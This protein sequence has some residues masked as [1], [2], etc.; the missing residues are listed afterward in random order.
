M[1][2]ATFALAFGS[3]SKRVIEESNP[4][5]GIG[6]SVLCLSCRASFKRLFFDSDDDDIS[7]R[8]RRRDRHREMG[9]SSNKEA[10]VSL[11]PRN[12]LVAASSVNDAL[13]PQQQQHQPP[14]ARYEVKMFYANATSQAKCASSLARQLYDAHYYHGHMLRFDQA[15]SCQGQG[16][17]GNHSWSC[18]A[19]GIRAVATQEPRPVGP[20]HKFVPRPRFI[21]PPQ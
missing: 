2:L 11:T 19:E 12:L 13:S 3:C 7:T 21:P 18:H 1:G 8:H 16:N 17:Q 15:V 20:T 6:G 5:R 10:N 9:A 14:T 4:R